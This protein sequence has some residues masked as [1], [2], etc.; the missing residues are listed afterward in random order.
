MPK[1]SSLLSYSALLSFGVSVW[2]VMAFPVI[3]FSAEVILRASVETRIDR[4]RLSQEELRS[5]DASLQKIVD[6]DKQ[7]LA[8]HF[9]VNLV[10]VGGFFLAAACFLVG[11]L[12]ARQL[13]LRLAAA[14]SDTTGCA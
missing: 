9:R 7:L 12:K 13:E 8:S 11:A 6:N 10:C 4:W 3:K 5:L 14:L 1:L 2:C